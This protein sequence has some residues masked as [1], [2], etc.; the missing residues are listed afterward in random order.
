MIFIHAADANVKLALSNALARRFPI[1]GA[2]APG[3][4]PAEYRVA[5]LVRDATTLP[6]CADLAARRVPVVVLAPIPTGEEEAAYAAAGATAYL[7]LNLQ[8]SGLV[9]A[10]GSALG[11]PG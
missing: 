1:N 7:P 2:S 9:Q 5:V 11:M 10:V 8:L 3:T 6:L 4:E